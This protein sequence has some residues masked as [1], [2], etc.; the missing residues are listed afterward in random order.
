ML[1]VPQ[2]PVKD[3]NR[4]LLCSTLIEIDRGRMKIHGWTHEEKLLWATDGVFN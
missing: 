4:S 2:S 3:S 1:Q